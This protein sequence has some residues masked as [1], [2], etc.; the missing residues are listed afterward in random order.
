M[1]NNNMVSAPQLYRHTVY[2]RLGH[3]MMPLGSCVWHDMAWNAVQCRNFVKAASPR[4]CKLLI[5][6]YP[7]VSLAV[8]I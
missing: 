2:V 1:C 5:S 6:G 3:N 8:C 4:Y 7:K